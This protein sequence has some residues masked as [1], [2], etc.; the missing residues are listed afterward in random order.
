MTVGSQC[1]TVTVTLVTTYSIKV[2]LLMRLN[3][4]NPFIHDVFLRSTLAGLQ[5]SSLLETEQQHNFNSLSPPYCESSDSKCPLFKILHINEILYLDLSLMKPNFS[6]TC[7]ILTEIVRY[8]LSGQCINFLG[9]TASPF[10]FSVFDSVRAA[11][12]F[13]LR[14]M[15]MS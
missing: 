8:C 2:R 6:C 10:S 15:A 3:I 11:A 7:R 4:I 5:L 14:V 1:M 9:T 13:C 12:A